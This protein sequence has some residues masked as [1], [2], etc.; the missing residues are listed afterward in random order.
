MSSSADGYIG[1]FPEGMWGPAVVH[2][3]GHGTAHGGPALGLR[4]GERRSRLY[5]TS[6]TRMPKALPPGRSS[7]CTVT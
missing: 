4:R 7:T 6:I 2:E 5:L 3:M 1:R